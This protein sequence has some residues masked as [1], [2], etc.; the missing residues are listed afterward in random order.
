MTFIHIELFP[1]DKIMLKK[2]QHGHYSFLL[3]YYFPKGV[4]V[5]MCVK[6]SYI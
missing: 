4:H 2:T 6:Y 3:L 5:C 1:Y